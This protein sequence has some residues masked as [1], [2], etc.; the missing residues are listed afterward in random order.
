MK[1]EIIRQ[2]ILMHRGGLKEATDAQLKIIWD[3]LTAETQKQYL[4]NA[5]KERKGSNAVSNPSKRK[6]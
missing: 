1:T 2:A 5:K 3:S 6:V 4:E